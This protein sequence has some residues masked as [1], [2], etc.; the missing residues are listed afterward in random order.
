MIE[1]DLEADGTTIG[2]VIEAVITQITIGRATLDQTTDK[3]HNGLAKIEVKVEIGVKIMTLEVEVEIETKGSEENP[4]LDLTQ[5]CVLIMIVQGV[6]GVE[7]MTTLQLNALILRLMKRQIMR[8]Q[9]LPL[10]K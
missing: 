8:M 1:I 2:Q 4:G 3:T 6:I 5:E 10:C 7:S 9:I